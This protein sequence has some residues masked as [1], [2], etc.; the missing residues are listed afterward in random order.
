MPPPPLPTFPGPHLRS[1]PGVPVGTVVA[2]MGEVY[3]QNP[4]G[5]QVPSVVPQGW[6]LC[7]GRALLRAMFP[8]LFATLG[9]RYLVAGDTQ[10]THFRVPDLRGYFLR[11]VDPTGTIDPDLSAR[12]TPANTPAGPQYV[13]STQPCA[14]QLHE[15]RYQLPTPGTANAGPAPVRVAATTPTPTDAV[16]TPTNQPFTASSEHETRPTNV[17]VYY[18]IRYTSGAFPWAAPLGGMFAP[19]C[20]G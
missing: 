13:G 14:L 20:S 7:D 19:W 15:H 4:S 9:Y 6:L 8:E 18:L 16:V 12:K 3:G 17:A 1:S 11:G 10:G 5:E 2:F